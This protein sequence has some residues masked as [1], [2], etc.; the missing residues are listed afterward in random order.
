M[1]RYRWTTWLASCWTFGLF[2][3]FGSCEYGAVNIRALVFLRHMLSFLL[4]L[5]GH[6]GVLFHQRYK[7]LLLSYTKLKISML[8]KLLRWGREPVEEE[9]GEGIL[10]VR[11]WIGAKYMIYLPKNYTKTFFIFYTHSTIILKRNL[12]FLKEYLRFINTP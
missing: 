12:T 6:T 7:K 1:P 4:E 3:P 8:W 9:G 11:G 2:L 10:I 5:L